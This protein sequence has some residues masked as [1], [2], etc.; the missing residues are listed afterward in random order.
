M[1][2][3]KKSQ[4]FILIGLKKIIFTALNKD[5]QILLNKN[6]PLN[7]K[8]LNENLGSLKKFLDQNIIDSEKRLNTY[9]E[10]IN[11]IIDYHDFVSIDVSTIY[12]FSNKS[13]Q[14]DNTSSYLLNIKNEVLKSMAN[15]DLV[16][17]L[18]TKF[19]V[20]G[21]DYL[22][23]SNINEHKNIFLEIKFICLKNNI[24]Q[25]FKETFSKYEIS[26]NKVFDHSYV[27]SFRE[28]NLDNIF[29][30]ADKLKKGH[31][32]KEILL[33]EKPLKDVGFFNK[34]FNFFN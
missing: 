26:I 18:I 6:L 23:I 3:I 33:V 2:D 11:L 7:D 25:D 32:Q 15:Y 16:H 4:F 10:E 13:K 27:N 21:K 19:I 8:D 5:N 14:S 24:L 20:D 17:M 1:D 29:D 31:N 12:N 30:L 34:F 9:I 28:P 22:S